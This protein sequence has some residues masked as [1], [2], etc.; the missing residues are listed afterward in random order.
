MDYLTPDYRPTSSR[1]GSNVSRRSSGPRPLI[2]C[3]PAMSYSPEGSP[4]PDSALHRG[5]VISLFRELPSMTSTPLDGTRSRWNS[6]ARKASRYSFVDQQD[7]PKKRRKSFTNPETIETFNKAENVRLEEHI[8]LQHLEQLLHEFEIHDPEDILIHEETGYFPAKVFKRTPGCMNV[9]EFKNT[10]S[11]VLETN[12]YD[13][14]LERL[15]TKLDTSC[16]GYVD[17]DEFCTYL[18]LL[19]R[20]NDYLRTKKEIPFLVEPKIRHAVHNRQETTTKII[21]VE[22]PTR[23]LTISKEGGMSVWNSNISYERNYVI[24]DDTT[25]T[26]GQK[27]RFKMWITD[28]VYMPNCHKIAIGSTSRDIRFYDVSTTQYFEEFHLF[29]MTDVP[30]CF[31]YWYDQKNPN[32]RSLL[33]FGV[34]SGDINLLYFNKPITQLF[35][36]PFQSEGGVQKIF[37]QD[38]HQH[39]KYVQFS[40]L[41]NIHP[42]II[43]QVR[44]LPDSDSIISSCDSDRKS[45]VIS[46]VQSLKRS[47][48]FRVDKGVECFDYNKNIN[49]LATGSSDHYIR[50]WNP[51]VTSKPITV[52]VGHATGVIGI[53]IHEGFRQVFSYSKDAVIKVWDIREHTCLQTVQLKFPSSIHG[54]MPEHGQF[55]LHLQG[56]PHSAV[57]VTSNDYI[58]MLKLGQVAA[59]QSVM[60]TTHDT[61]LCCAIYNHFFKQ[62]VT[63]CDSSCIAVWDIESGRK[64]IV[65][66]NAH[67]DEEI[68][69]MV[70]DETYR[71]LMTGAR[72]GTIKVWNFQNGH[73]L[74]KLEA[75]AEAE[76]TG[77]LPVRDKKMILSVGWS[78]LLTIYD[79]SDQ[80]N[81]Y[82]TANQDW[83]GGQLHKDDIL[84]IDFCPP[85]FVATAGFDGEIIVWDLETEKMFIRL[86][87]GQQTNLNRKIED[88]TA[89]LKNERPNSRHKK[90][91][92]VQKGEP[93]PVDKVMF[94]RDRAAIRFTESAVVVSSEGGVLHWWNIYTPKSE[95]GFFSATDSVDDSVLAMCSKPRNTAVITGDTA[96][97]IKVWDTSDYCVKPDPRHRVRTRPPLEAAF[98]AHDAAV[99]S[100]EYLEHD[101]RGFIL[102]ASTDKTARLWTMEGYYVGTFGQKFPWDLNDASTWAHPK[103]PFNM[104]DE[105]KDE[106]NTE[107]TEAPKKTSTTSTPREDSDVEEEL[108]RGEDKEETTAE[109]EQQDETDKPESKTKL[110]ARPMSVVVRPAKSVSSEFPRDAKLKYRSQTFAFGFERTDPSKTFLGV[111]VEKEFA[112]K[113]LD[114]QE[115]RTVFGEINRGTTSRFG[116]L[117]SPYQALTTTDFKDVQLPD[118]LP[119]SDRLKSL[120]F[121]GIK[122]TESDITALNF[123]YEV[124]D[125]PPS[126]EDTSFSRG[127]LTSKGSDSSTKLPPIKSGRWS[128]FPDKLGGSK[129]SSTVA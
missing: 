70:F 64:S 87:K 73:N 36:T 3:P 113:K 1:R 79:D 89:S 21:S 84:S 57:L 31:D 68:T 126:G 34:D 114:R 74:H 6:Q 42:G 18:L 26:I 53:A 120:G 11:K 48:V 100:V 90:K 23:Y 101:S 128:K 94:L 106:S 129:K 40:V 19:Y 69:C 125:S 123:S 118:K 45:V 122:P 41:S 82:I 93:V 55:P 63:G 109:E 9:E 58:G 35:E 88:L 80:D 121:T 105:E 99:V 44:F 103:T 65:F 51:Y 104:D 78:R 12:E 127:N 46:D 95:L 52:L 39:T 10:I 15:F 115:R 102:S 60:P 25:E 86:R 108:E 30:Y 75:A 71:R 67:G 56:A 76:V 112:R 72:N 66:S 14:Y 28:V 59:P 91:H 49:I 77:I 16:D 61:Q 62:V 20:E 43:R 110:E 8:K 47:Y 24:E 33:A 81:M 38:L 83:K 7:V 17:W 116:K 29:A 5:S 13:D 98:K 96:G 124:P 32:N 2:A 117:C 97:N 92:R 50:L 27:R 107:G 119:V 22:N 37:M 85:N 54:R 111:K 4:R